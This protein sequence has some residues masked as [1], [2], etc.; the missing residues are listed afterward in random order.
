MA[1]VEE[2]RA[3]VKQQGTKC[4]LLESMCKRLATENDVY[5]DFLKLERR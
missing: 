4:E 5:R 3:K 2:L 1:Q